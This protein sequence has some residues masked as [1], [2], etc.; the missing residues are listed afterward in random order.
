[1]RSA[2]LYCLPTPSNHSR[3]SSK[4]TC[5]QEPAAS[6]SAQAEERVSTCRAVCAEAEKDLEAAKTRVDASKQEMPSATQSFSAIGDVHS[7]A[8]RIAE[9][10]AALTAGSH[11]GNAV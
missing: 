7:P 6:E 11:D 10:A 4:G 5:R 3:R 9:G 2:A 8:M 1:M